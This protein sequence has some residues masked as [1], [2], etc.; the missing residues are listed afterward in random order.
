MIASTTTGCVV[1]RDS[2][3]LPSEHPILTLTNTRSPLLTKDEIPGDMLSRM[4]RRA[5][6][7]EGLV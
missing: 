7:V 3:A 6:F 5:L 1:R 2:G 4:C